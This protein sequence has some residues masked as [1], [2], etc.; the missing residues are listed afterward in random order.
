MQDDS[1]SSAPQQPETQP[2]DVRKEL[3]QDNIAK[4]GGDRTAADAG[5]EQDSSFGAVEDEMS[6]QSD[7]Q[8][9]TPPMDGPDNLTHGDDDDSMD[10]DPQ[11]EISGG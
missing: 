3:A 2:A 7:M 4:S 6:G 8:P 11:Q 5:A 10:V 9:V 1:Q